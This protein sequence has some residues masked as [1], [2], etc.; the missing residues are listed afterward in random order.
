MPVSKVFPC[1]DFEFYFRSRRAQV[2]GVLR[3]TINTLYLSED[4][5]GIHASIRGCKFV[6]CRYAVDYKCISEPNDVGCAYRA[7]S[8]DNR[9]RT[10]LLVVRSLQSLIL[11]LALQDVSRFANHS[12]LRTV[13]LMHSVVLECVG[14]YCVAV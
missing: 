12:R 3:R 6:L 2:G 8:P 13:I 4:M 5:N 11:Q 9:A 14:S 7:F 10:M 1:G